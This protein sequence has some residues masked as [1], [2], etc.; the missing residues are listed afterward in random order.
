MT[1]DD[2]V[3]RPGGLAVEI[4]DGS[5]GTGVDLGFFLLGGFVVVVDGVAVAST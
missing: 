2:G 1:P 3:V 4:L 5:L